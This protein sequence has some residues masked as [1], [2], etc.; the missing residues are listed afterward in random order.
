MSREVK[1]HRGL[2]TRIVVNVALLLADEG[3]IEA[4][5]IRR[6]AAALQ[7]TPMAIYRHVRDK[8]H[9]LDLMADRLIGQLALAPPDALTWQEALR[10][11]AVS[12]LAVVRTHPAAPFLLARPFESAAALRIS[13]TMLAILDR[14]GFGPVESMR[15][16]QVLTGMILGPAI[17]R[18]TYAHAWREL[19]A[20]PVDEQAAPSVLPAA[21]FPYLSRVA[22]QP[23]DWSQGPAIDQLTIELWVA[24]VEELADREKRGMRVGNGPRGSVH[25]KGTSRHPR[26]K[27]KG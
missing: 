19:P 8:G 3:G 22:N 16:M 24:S 25:S 14:A 10:G 6:L 26:A 17:H 21:D 5:S 11:V 2:T 18:A 23:M 4:V 9:L 12:L 13:E 1:T 15:L 7:V 20:A 27:A